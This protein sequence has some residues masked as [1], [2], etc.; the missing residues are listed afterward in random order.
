MLG[1]KHVPVARLDLAVMRGD[2]A[3]SRGDD[4]AV[5]RLAHLEAPADVLRGD[6][7]GIGVEGDVALDV[8]EPLMEQVGFGDPPGQAAQGR[9]LGGEQLAGRG[10]EVPLGALVDA[11]T[12]GAR[13]AVGV[14]P[15]GEAPAISGTGIM[16]R[17]V[18]VSTTTWVLSI[19]QVWQAP[20][21]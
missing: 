19:M 5:L 9:V 16:S 21:M 8:D 6:G 13:L 2:L 12:P 18:P 15:V 4:D 1:P 11:V 17:P 3:R 7:V 20:S 14:G 10:L